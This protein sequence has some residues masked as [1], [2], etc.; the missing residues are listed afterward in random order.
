MRS[1]GESEV[2]LPRR[3]RELAPW[4]HL[5]TAPGEYVEEAA[6]IR[7]LLQATADGPVERVLELGSGGGNNAS[8]LRG[9]FQLTLVDASEQMLAVSR[10]LNP[11][12]EHLLGDMR[13][14]RLG[15]TFDAVLVHD[16]VMYLTDERELRMALETVALHARPGGAVLVAP[17][18]TRESWKPATSSGGH[19]GPDG[20][21]LRYLEWDWD[22]DPRDTVFTSA[23]AYLLREPDGS[24]RVEHDVNRCGVFPRATWLRLLDEAG[25]DSTVVPSAW[26]PEIFVGRRR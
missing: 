23:M 8:H 16:A 19:D 10:T 1:A 22:D 13:S 17:D 2:D 21:A 25:V 6:E 11:E 7:D 5:L 14:L 15:R 9:S 12:C 3:Y 26:G 4:F 24:V 20:R 18:C